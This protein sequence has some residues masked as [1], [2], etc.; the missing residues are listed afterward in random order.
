MV[1]YA[2]FWYLV[3]HPDV[4]YLK[5]AKNGIKMIMYHFCYWVWGVIVLMAAIARH[6]HRGIYTSAALVVPQYGSVLVRNVG[7]H[8]FICTWIHWRC[9]CGNNLRKMQ[10][11]KEFVFQAHISGPFRHY[12]PVYGAHRNGLLAVPTPVFPLHSQG[13]VSSPRDDCK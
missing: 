12:H 6:R 8:A 3:R 1:C 4:G 9:G 2:S 7:I 5:I 10:M 13:S 11:C